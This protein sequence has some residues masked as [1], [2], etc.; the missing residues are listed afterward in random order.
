[1]FRVVKVSSLAIVAVGIMACGKTDPASDYSNLPSKPFENHSYT[2]TDQSLHAPAFAIKISGGTPSFVEGQPGSVQ[3][4]VTPL[5][6]EITDEVLTS[7][8]KPSW[9]KLVKVGSNTWVLQGTPPVGTAM[10]GSVSVPCNITA[11]AVTSNPS[12]SNLIG[13]IQN[14]VITVSKT[15]VQPIIGNFNGYKDIINEGESFSFS[16]DVN[17]PATK[18][19]P[20]DLFL[21]PYDS[22]ENKENFKMDGSRFIQA[23]MKGAITQGANGVWTHHYTFSTEGFVFNPR[24]LPDPTANSVKICETFVALSVTSNLSHEQPTRCTVVRFTVQSPEV[25]FKDFP[26]DY[27]PITVKA[28]TQATLKFTAIIPNQRGIAEVKNVTPNFSKWPG[29]PVMQACTNGDG[30]DVSVQ[31]C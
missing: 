6:R 9:S 20:A 8:D 23:D 26:F 4:S 30:S 31:V 21:K 29:N 11:H 24:L 15:G 5:F 18:L 28:G 25:T 13:E 17:D 19:A 27:V 14:L 22:G 10:G 3:F 16:V 7:S 12:M 1:M 2:N